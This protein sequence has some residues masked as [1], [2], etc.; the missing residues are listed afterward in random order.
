MKNFNTVL[1]SLGS[2]GTMETETISKNGA[3]P[4]SQMSRKPKNYFY[5]RQQC[6]FTQSP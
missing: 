1:R 2:I 6:F 5:V 4:K 3:S